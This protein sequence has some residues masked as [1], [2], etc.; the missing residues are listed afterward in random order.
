VKVELGKVLLRNGG[1]VREMPIR[2]QDMKL[3]DEMLKQQYRLY[4]GPMQFGIYK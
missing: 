1:F 4:R 3:R 2:P